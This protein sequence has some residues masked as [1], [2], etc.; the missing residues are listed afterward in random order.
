MP[1]IERIVFFGTPELA[2]PTL[3]ALVRA[4]KP[5]VAV[6]T[7]PARPAGRGKKLTDPP[8]AQRARALSLPVLQPEKVSRPEFIHQLAAL[9]PDLAVVVAFGQ[10]FSRALLAVPRLGCVNLHASLLPRYRGASPIQAAIAAGEEKTGVTT[11]EMDAGLDTGP[12][13]LQEE[14]AI[15]PEET[16][17]ELGERLAELGGRLMVETVRALEA[18]RVTPRPQP[19]GATY[20]PR[21]VR[22]AGRV[23]WAETAQVLAA[24]RRA[25]TPWPGLFSSLRGAPVKLCAARALARTAGAAAPGTIL[26]IGEEGVLVACGGSTVLAVTAL[27]RPGRKPLAAAE[28][29][30]GERL[31][32]H[33]SFS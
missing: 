27:Q 21:L 11:M 10:I 8:V 24:R 16:A 23:D 9:A 25:Y 2:V 33:E 14:T 26:E 3:D 32:V 12:I 18:G 22:E 28:F 15:G 13:L 31:A 29:A 30:R 6:V 20:A 4:G 5:P 17:G 7:Q 19:E 1:E